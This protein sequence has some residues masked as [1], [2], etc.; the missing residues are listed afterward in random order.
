MGIVKSLLNTGIDVNQTY[1]NKLTALMW[2]AGYSNDV[3]PND[4]VAMIQLLLRKGALI[5]LKDNRGWTAMMTAANMGH[6]EVI[7]ILIKAGADIHTKSNDGKTAAKLASA[8]GH[9]KAV[10]ILRASGAN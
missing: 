3:P 5:D 6:W 2:A 1:G 9:Q 8:S 10:A 7:E 4:A